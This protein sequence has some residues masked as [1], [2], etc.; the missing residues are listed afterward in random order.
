MR[1]VLQSS[2]DDGRAAQATPPDHEPGRRQARRKRPFLRQ[3]L[4]GDFVLDAADPVA[5]HECIGEARL[6]PGPRSQGTGGEGRDG[7]SGASDARVDELGVAERGR[8]AGLEVGPG[9]FHQDMFREGEESGGTVVVA[10]DAS[11][12]FFF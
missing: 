7:A 8:L 6:L 5:G 2:Q 11:F 10:R 3:A 9:A 12:L 4:G 1:L